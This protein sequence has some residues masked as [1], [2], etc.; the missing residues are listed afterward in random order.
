M[1]KNTSIVTDSDPAEFNRNLKEHISIMQN[2]G[3]EVEVHYST[4]INAYN[5]LM[6][7]ALVLGKEVKK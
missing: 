7:S 4:S 2:Q 5:V 3:F 1:I 6:Y